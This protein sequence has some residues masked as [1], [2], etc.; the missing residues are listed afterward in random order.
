MKKENLVSQAG[1]IVERANALIS[2]ELKRAGLK[3]ISPSHGD[4]FATLFKDGSCDMS[5]IANKINRTK[6]TTTVLIDKL[7]SLGY[8]QKLRCDEDSRVVKVSLSKKGE[9]LKPLFEQISQR[10]NS[11]VY[12]GLSDVESLLLETLLDRV[13]NNLKD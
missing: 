13:I 2:F 12:F 3:N 9:E 5:Y 6:P 10:L 11:K 1:K 7:E 4:I 8:V